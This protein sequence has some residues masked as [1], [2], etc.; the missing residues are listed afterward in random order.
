MYDGLAAGTYYVFIT[1]YYQNGDFVAYTLSSNATAYGHAKDIEPNDAP[2]QART[3]LANDS[4]T[5]HIGFLQNGNGKNFID[6]WKI[7]Y[8][9]TG[10]LTLN[11]DINSKLSDGT[12]NPY[13][14]QLFRDT[15]SS[16]VW[17]SGFSASTGN[18]TFS[19][20]TPGYYWIRVGI[21]Y[22]YYPSSFVAYAINNQFVQS[23]I[24]GAAATVI[25]P[26]AC[27]STNSLRITCSGSQPPYKV[28]LYRFGV[29]YGN[30]AITSKVK[31]FTSL[32]HGAYY[33]TVLG[34]GASGNAYGTSNT[35]IIVPVPA[36]GG[37]TGITAHNAK[38]NW[39]L[40]PC[41]S[42]Y[43]VH[44]RVQ[45]ATTWIVKKTP[46]NL[47][48]LYL[49]SLAANTIYQWQVASVDTANHTGGVGDYSPIATFTTSSAFTERS[50][51]GD[52]I[53]FLGET[54]A[55]YPNPAANFV[56]LQFNA[57]GTKQAIA[58]IKDGEGRIVW[59]AANAGIS[60]LNGTIVDVSRWQP[61]IYYV[62]VKTANT[63][64]TKKFFVS[65]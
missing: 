27:A 54:V 9:G 12:Y 10:A 43:S 52:E 32:P 35:V 23:N 34:D 62:E 42:Y 63:T 47:N 33:V 30:V 51:V 39:T 18:I 24:A 5:G 38:L 7:N 64:G 48:R 17:S 49:A 25:Q 4:V 56:R 6:W 50:I 11:V 16:P 60:N 65:R 57:Q 3:I 31:N 36:T 55:L 46:G 45:G 8:T 41:A 37:T 13:Y 14:V 61:G 20:L 2:Y 29:P 58:S 15:A 53:S 28:Q 40:Q 1:T 19:T 21:D 22:G 44:Y 59:S 26:V